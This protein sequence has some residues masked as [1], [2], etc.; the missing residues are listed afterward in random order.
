[1]IF[2]C[3]QGSHFVLAAL[4]KVPGG[5]KEHWDCPV[6]SC[7]SPG[8]HLKHSSAP[9]SGEK[10]PA[11]H[12]MHECGPARRLC[13]PDRH[14]W[15]WPPSEYC[16]SGHHGSKHTKFSAEAML[17]SSQSLYL[18]GRFHGHVPQSIRAKLKFPPSHF[19]RKP[20]RSHW[21]STRSDHKR[22]LS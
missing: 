19:F 14:C 22:Q 1:M 18:R 4:A 8:G 20:S 15:H 3:G 10:V 17:L 6:R 21:N 5:H 2:W 7:T 11:W 13:V 16:P 12:G 9:K